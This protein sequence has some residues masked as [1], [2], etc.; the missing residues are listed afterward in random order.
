MLAAPLFLRNAYYLG[1]VQL[2]G[3]YTI[4]SQGNGVIVGYAGQFT[5]GQGAVYAVGAYASAILAVSLGWSV[6]LSVVG[7]TAISALIGLV[8]GLPALRLRTHYLAMTTLGFALVVPQLILNWE[9]LTGGWSGISGIPRPSIGDHVFTRMEYYY[10]IAAATV[11]ML[12]F[13]HNLLRSRWRLGFLAIHDSELATASLGISVYRVKLTA[14]LIASVLTG[15]GGA[16]YAHYLGFIS[17][18]NFRLDMS[19]L[20]LTT[21]VIGGPATFSGPLLGTI[22]F[23]LL[24]ELLVGLRDYLLVVYGGLLVVS[25]MVIPDGVVGAVSGLWQRL[26]RP[27]V[28]R[29]SALAPLGLD[30]ELSRFRRPLAAGTELL[31]LNALTKRFGGVAALSDV[32]MTVR[33]GTVHALIGPNGSGKTTL[34]NLISGFYPASAGQIVFRGQ[35]RR[36]T[37]PD[38]IALDGIARTFQKPKIFL[39]L[40]VLE[41][42]MVGFFPHERTGV[43]GAM[44]ALP[45]ARAERHRSRERAEEL[46]RFVGLYDRRDDLAKNLPHGQQRFLEIARALTLDPHLVLLDEPAAGLSGAE[47]DQLVDLILHLKA[48]GRAILLVEHHVNMVMKVADRITVL[49][50]GQKICDGTPDEVRNSPEVIAAYLG[51]SAAHA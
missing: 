42:V 20:F 17:P 11:L 10:V 2:I 8:L 5:L 13:T 36:K 19:I 33:T 12:W 28:V 7:A 37:T 25:Q 48:Q 40:T 47:L 50:H 26:R 29:G 18:D 39:H 51:T 1:L 34:L 15:F 16:L 23:V 32:D 6:W 4:V 21:V 9:R 35:V 24:P 49:N 41:N 31:R 22:I 30:R 27:G 46:L 43:V 38:A 14:F 45:R 44:L 3:I